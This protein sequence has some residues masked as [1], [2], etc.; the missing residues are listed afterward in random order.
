MPNFW[1]YAQKA[2]ADDQKMPETFISWKGTITINE[3]M[4]RTD[5]VSDNHKA[6]VIAI[7]S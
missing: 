5:V 2:T 6:H 3:M 4:T 7:W 1:P